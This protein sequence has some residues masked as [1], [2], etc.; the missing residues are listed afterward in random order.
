M[1]IIKVTVIGVKILTPKKFFISEKLLLKK[2]K[3][4]NNIFK[5]K[6]DINFA[7]Y[8]LNNFFIGVCQLPIFKKYR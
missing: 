6:S 2:G 3:Y 7:V 4:G 5:K 8:N 1:D